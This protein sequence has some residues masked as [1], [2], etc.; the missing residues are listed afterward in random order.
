MNDLLR[1]AVILPYNHSFVVKYTARA[2]RFVDYTPL[3]ALSALLFSTP[4]PLLAT[5]QMR[6]VDRPPLVAILFGAI[7][8]MPTVLRR[9]RWINIAAV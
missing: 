2:A 6:S 3:L 4:T 9:G 1:G 7:P 8:K 5:L